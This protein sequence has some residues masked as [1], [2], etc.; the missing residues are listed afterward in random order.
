LVSICIAAYH[1]NIDFHSRVRKD[2]LGALA[3]TLAGLEPEG[4]AVLLAEAVSA[5]P[6]ECLLSISAT[7]LLISSL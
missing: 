6:G 7:L 1:L 5:F 4:A 3:A 2:C